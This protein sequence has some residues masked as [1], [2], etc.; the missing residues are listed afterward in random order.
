MLVLPL[1]QT[2]LTPSCGA[3]LSVIYNIKINFDFLVGLIILSIDFG[4]AK[5]CFIVFSQFLFVVDSTLAVC[6]PFAVWIHPPKEK[7]YNWD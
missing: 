7:C 4:T 1:V 6:K 2:I 3:L 5:D